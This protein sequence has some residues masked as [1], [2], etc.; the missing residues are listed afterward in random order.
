LRGGR[1]KKYTKTLKRLREK[2]KKAMIGKKESYVR[3]REN[4]KIMT[5]EGYV[6]ARKNTMSEEGGKP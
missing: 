1:G 2:R 4:D 5:A 3:G 6:K